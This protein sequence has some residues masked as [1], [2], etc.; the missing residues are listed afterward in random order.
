MPIMF[1]MTSSV[2]L[3]EESGVE[4]GV[5]VSG[6]EVKLFAASLSASRARGVYQTQ[7]HQQ[8]NQLDRW[9]ITQTVFGCNINT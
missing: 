9:T 6:N 1:S 7:V 8:S 5:E 4:S 3:H 2:L